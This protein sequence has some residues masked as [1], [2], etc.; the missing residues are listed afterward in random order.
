M[1]VPI[2]PRHLHVDA[3]QLRQT[4]HLQDFFLRTIGDDPTAVHKHHALNLG[5]DV[6]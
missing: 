1:V 6:G 4:F 5:D 3:E 2:P